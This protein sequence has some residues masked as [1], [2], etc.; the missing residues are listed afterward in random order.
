MIC[1]L[2][3]FCGSNDIFVLKLMSSSIHRGRFP[4]LTRPETNR[5]TDIAP[6]RL[7]RDPKRKRPRLVFQAS[8]FSQGVLLLLVPSREAYFLMTFVTTTCSV[9]VD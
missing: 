8:I 9:D 3:E 6:A 1:L 2:N 4:T 7:R 5:L